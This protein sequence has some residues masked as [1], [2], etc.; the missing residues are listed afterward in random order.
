MNARW[1]QESFVSATLSC[2]SFKQTGTSKPLQVYLGASAGA[3]L[4]SS[5]LQGCGFS[6]CPE[7]LWNQHFKDSSE[8]GESSVHLQYRCR[9]LS[10]LSSTHRDVGQ[11]GTHV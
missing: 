5:Y 10:L 2:P 7:Q 4:L 1:R 6:S 9:D 3:Q 11:G 8:G